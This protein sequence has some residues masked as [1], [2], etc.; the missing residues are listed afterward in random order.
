[1]NITNLN[2]F[3]I[4]LSQEAHR[5]AMEFATQQLTPQ[6]GKRVYLNTL[7]VYAVHT[8]LNY[9]QIET[10]LEQSDSWQ[11]HKQIVSD[12]DLSDLVLPGI[13]KLECRPILPE[14]T[15]FNVSLKTPEEA[16]EK[17]VGYVAVQVDDNL[18]NVDV[19]GFLPATDVTSESQQIEISQLQPLD[20]LIDYIFALVPPK[21]NL[22]TLSQLFPKKADV[23]LQT[24][25]EL[26]WQAWE[27]F[28]D[29]LTPNSKLAFRRN[30]MLQ[31]AI[32]N[33]TQAGIPLVKEL[34]LGSQKVALIVESIL[35][36]EEKIGIT[37][38]LHPIGSKYLPH[39]LQII[40]L[41]E[42]GNVF[43]EDEVKD[44]TNFIR[45]SPF[46]GEIGDKFCVKVVGDITLAEYF[47]I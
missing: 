36:D 20:S 23:Y 47:D 45:L 16:T 46:V 44:Y 11:L 39:P 3:I 7:A 19:I 12:V 31:S 14:E 1:M 37:I 34:N 29:N 38:E 24:L 15:A 35:Q 17:I 22:V 32:K 8:Y 2:Q 21:Q 41:D 40:V 18:S 30:D 42:S 26:G 27:Q 9:L 6:K 10:S 13:G 43:N 5:Y 4:P 28:I 33:K 25:A